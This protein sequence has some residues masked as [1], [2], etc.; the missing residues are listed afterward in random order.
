MTKADNTSVK[1]INQHG[2]MGFVMFIAFIG[3]FLYFS[4]HA[5]NFGDVFFAFVKALVWPG[6]AVYH[7]LQL[8]GA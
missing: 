8:L 5:S 4:Q 3:A 2:P 1:I 6:F 7:V